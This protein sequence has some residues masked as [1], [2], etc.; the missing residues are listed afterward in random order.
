M[1]E[2]V[3]F[4]AEHVCRLTG[5]S[6]RQLRYWDTTG[7]FSPTD[8]PSTGGR[9]FARIYSFRDVVGLRAIAIL[10]NSHHVPLQELRRVGAWLKQHH[11]SPWSGLRLGLS[12]RKVAFV[13]PT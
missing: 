8:V 2:I 13:H 3:A 10:R 1:S 9:I 7:F 6:R 12:N 4:T 11:D 5:L